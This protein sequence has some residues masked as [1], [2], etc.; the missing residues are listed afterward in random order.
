MF[1]NLLYLSVFIISANLSSMQLNEFSAGRP[2]AQPDSNE[3]KLLGCT[4]SRY[5]IFKNR[6]AFYYHVAKKLI[7]NNDVDV[8]TCFSDGSTPLHRAKNYKLV[9]LLLKTGANPNLINSR[10][11]TPLHFS[12][13]HK[14][15]L[16]LAY[17]AD[18]NAKDIHGRSTLLT[19]LSNRDKATVKLLIKAGAD[20]EAKDNQG[21]TALQIAKNNWSHQIV[22]ML[23][24]AGAQG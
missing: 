13:F 18:V 20:L 21:M 10:Y 9:E 4:R 14:A 16:L 8:N 7:K 11:Q 22:K 2:I 6:D 19:H 3:E 23:K 17:G 24:N 1:K 5:G 15:K 12:D